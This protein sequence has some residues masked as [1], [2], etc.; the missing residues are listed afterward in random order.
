MIESAD[1]IRNQAT[2]LRLKLEPHDDRL[3]GRILATAAGP[4]EA[5]ILPYIVEVR[6]SR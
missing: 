1:A 4:G 3:T 2:S 5:A 6:R